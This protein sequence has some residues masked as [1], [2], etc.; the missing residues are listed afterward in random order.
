MS[1]LEPARKPESRTPVAPQMAW[2]VAVIGTIALV[3]FGIVFFRLWYLQ[4]LS[5]GKFVAQASAQQ[6]RPLPVLAPRGQIL[7][8]NGQVLVSS[9]TTS[10]VRIVPAKLPESLAGEFATYREGIEHAVKQSAPLEARQKAIETRLDALKSTSAPGAERRRLRSE[11][12][13]ELNAMKQQLHRV[14]AVAVPRLAATQ[15]LDRRL[16]TRLGALLK[17]SPRKIVELIIHGVEVTPY[18]PVTIDS[19]AKAGQRAVLAER[20]SEFPGVEQGP[21]AQR[22]YPYGEMAAQIFGTVGPINARELSEE[23]FKGVPKGAVVG[24]SGLEYEYDNYLRGTPGEQEVS[25]NAA[26]EPTGTPLKE[27]PPKRGYDLQTTIDLPLQIEAERA[28]RED[29]AAAH[30]RGLPANGA[31][32]VA[33]NPLNGEVLAMGSYPSY[34]PSFFTKPFTEAEFKAVEGT[35][36]GTT[37]GRALLNRAIQGGYATGSTFK[38]YTAMAALEAGVITPTQE[39]GAGTYIE[40]G[41]LKFH[42]NAS[43]EFGNVN[44][45]KAL[46]VSSDVYFFTVGKRAYEHGGDI[47]QKMAHRLGIG[48]HTG[49]DLPGEN[50][51]LVPERRWLEGLEAE[52]RRCTRREHK[53]CGYVLEPNATWTVGDNMN[54]ALGQGDLLTNPLQMA[55]AYST[56]V[57]AFRNNGHGWR[58]TPHLGR[59]ID[60][61]NGELVRTL[62][63][64]PGKANINLNPEDLH[65]VFEGIHAAT[66]GPGGTS[67]ADWAG[68]PQ[69]LHETYGKTGT[70]ERFG[71]VEQAW[72][73]CYIASEKHPIVIAVA[74]EQGRYGTE[75]A[76]P[77]ARLMADQY[78]H[79]P[80]RLIVG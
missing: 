49:I 73:M 71:Y 72:Y 48:D 7:A 20:K 58:P 10:E 59:Q 12:E 45:V 56:L 4:I 66:V 69:G 47:I 21:V 2:R 60:N 15:T 26:G 37:G 74:V 9:Q 22:A 31:A 76:A 55:L 29:L 43:E 25:V 35:A 17:L 3:M 75:S 44:L 36:S 79:R 23:H 63:F 64:P 24:Q 46:E 14:G 34:D 32:F 77:V 53:P 16:F 52:E 80:K 8:S 61:A 6:H 5:G 18:A 38:P 11:G 30:N 62:K 54:L 28:L 65:Y 39:F 33:L 27:V 41:G 51:G 68:W 13:R 42:N 19:A 50:V 1:S 57:D 67:T 78:F 70:A 40:V